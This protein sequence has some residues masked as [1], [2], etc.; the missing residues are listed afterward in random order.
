MPVKA[1]SR[2]CPRGFR[3]LFPARTMPPFSHGHRRPVRH[4]GC[5]GI[6]HSQ[7]RAQGERRSEVRSRNPCGLASAQPGYVGRI[8]GTAVSWQCCNVRGAMFLGC[9]VSLQLEPSSCLP[10]CQRRKRLRPARAPFFFFSG[11]G[12]DIKRGIP[13]MKVLL[14]HPI[15][16]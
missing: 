15:T 16:W 13:H 10:R 6:I 11:G 4:D 7:S 14:Q 2:K 12:G 9:L 8:N 3:N 5:Q 1:H